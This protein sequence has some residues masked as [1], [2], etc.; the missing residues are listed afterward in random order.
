MY[1]VITKQG[2][3]PA[4]ERK[5]SHWHGNGNIDPGHT[6]FDAINE[7]TRGIA[8]LREDSGAIAIFMTIDEIDS[9]F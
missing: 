7:M 4:A 3:F 6:Y 8:I 1:I 5:E 2:A 9:E